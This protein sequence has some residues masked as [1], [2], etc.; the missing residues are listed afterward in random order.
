M[1]RQIVLLP[2]ACVVAGLIVLSAAGASPELLRHRPAASVPD[3]PALRA[4]AE[5]AARLA[6][7]AKLSSLG[8][9]RHDLKQAG[10]RLGIDGHAL[11]AQAQR[12]GDAVPGLKDVAAAAKTMRRGR[13]VGINLLAVLA[14]GLVG[15]PF[16]AAVLVPARYLARRR[17]LA[18][19]R[20][21]PGQRVPLS[22]R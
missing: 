15:V 3:Q 8:V 9:Q 18:M 7:L 14:A 6:A 11:V 19:D 10:R 13:V 20:G 17:R 1:I 21:T 22:T 12:A 2:I 16:V 4:L 5:Q